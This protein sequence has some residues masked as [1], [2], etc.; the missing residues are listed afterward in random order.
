MPQHTPAPAH[1]RRCA[2]CD[3]FATVAITTGQ[4]T[5]GGQRQTITLACRTCHGTGHTTPAAGLVRA[6]K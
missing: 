6:G 2:D 1:A 3:G 4:R 5:P